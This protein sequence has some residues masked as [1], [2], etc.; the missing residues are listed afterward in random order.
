MNKISSV[1]LP[2]CLMCVASLAFAAEPMMDKNGA[3]EKGAMSKDDM[4]KEGA[5]MMK[6]QPKKMKKTNDKM[7]QD[8]KMTMEPKK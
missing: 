2:L 4:N 7:E 3:M 8:G 6:A 5:M 1:L